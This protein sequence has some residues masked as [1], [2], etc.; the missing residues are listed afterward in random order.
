MALK[1]SWVFEWDICSGWVFMNRFGAK[2]LKFIL[3]E[4]C[5]RD[6]K[7]VIWQC[8]WSFMPS[9]HLHTIHLYIVV[10]RSQLDAL[11]ETSESWNSHIIRWTVNGTHCPHQK[12]GL[13]EKT[14]VMVLQKSFGGKDIFP[15]RFAGRII[16]FYQSNPPLSNTQF[17]KHLHELK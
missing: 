17:V 5:F 8:C 7:T 6:I 12:P 2:N 16:Y 14:N 9:Y 4:S 3:S 13:H 10:C 15:N 11:F 1:T